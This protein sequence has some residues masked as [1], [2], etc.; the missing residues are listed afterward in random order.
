MIQV[1]R[2]KQKGPRLPVALEQVCF[3][4]VSR[5]NGQADET[6]AAIDEPQRPPAHAECGSDG[7]TPLQSVFR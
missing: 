4:G 2:S 6:V 3:A 7:P 5:V 1:L